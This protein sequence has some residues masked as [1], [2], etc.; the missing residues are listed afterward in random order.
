MRV[1]P[2]LDPRKFQDGAVYFTG[3]FGRL[4]TGRKAEGLRSQE[5]I[6]LLAGSRIT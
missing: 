2:V 6:C 3:E 4:S 1:I 5:G